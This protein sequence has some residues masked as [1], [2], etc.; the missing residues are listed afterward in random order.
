MKNTTVKKTS[1]ISRIGKSVKSVFVSEK[2][3]PIEA[4]GFQTIGTHKGINYCGEKFDM[5]KK[6]LSETFR[7]N[8]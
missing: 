4:M 8:Y 1:I 2:N 3:P 5:H 7:E 6:E